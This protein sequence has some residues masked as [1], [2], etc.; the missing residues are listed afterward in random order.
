M[1]T[2]NKIDTEPE[3]KTVEAITYDM[4]ALKSKAS[5]MQIDFHPKIGGKK[6][7]EKIDTHIKDMESVDIVDGISEGVK[8]VGP[9]KT[10]REQE[11]HAREKILVT[12]TDNNS[13]DVDNP[14]IV[15]GVLNA[16]FKIGPVVIR[17]DTEQL[18]PRAIVEALVHKTMIKWVPSINRMTK[19]PTGNKVAET[20]NRYNIVYI[21]GK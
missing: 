11:K 18:V 17:K 5:L 8:S 4:E 21:D 13:L 2:D 16:F 3:L 15:H 10:I 20:R 19:R 12:I 14:T 7:K 6:L 9:N 1:S